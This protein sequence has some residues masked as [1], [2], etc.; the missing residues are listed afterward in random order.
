VQSL[1]EAQEFFEQRGP[2]MRRMTRAT[3][4]AMGRHPSDWEET[5][6]AV[7]AL[8][9]KGVRRL[10]EL[11]AWQPNLLKA[12]LLYAIRQHTA[13]RTVT[14]AGTKPRPVV[15]TGVDITVFM[16]TTDPIPSVVQTS[17]DWQA[18]RE[19]LSPRW[20]GYADDCLAVGPDNRALAERWGVTDGRACQIR[21]QIRDGYLA[22]LRNS[23]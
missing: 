17:L 5:H 20:Q 14:S 13:G 18:Y 3:L 9:W 22:F 16:A 1:R 15:V 23:L 7:Q 12:C 19:T 2:W 6:Q 11:G 10:L 4:G 21:R 8:A